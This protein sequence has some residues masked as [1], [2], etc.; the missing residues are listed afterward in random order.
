MTPER[1]EQIIEQCKARAIP[2]PEKIANKPFLWM[3]LEL[4]Y[5]AFFDLNT[6]RP[7]GMALCPIPWLCMRDYARTFE[8][9]EDQE[10]RLYYFIR[11][12]DDAFLQYH[13]KKAKSEMKTKSS[14]KPTRGKFK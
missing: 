7:V 9:D 3:G 12:M 8:F 14:T 6:C 5:H 1:E 4:F 10:E 13:D 2:L 11:Q